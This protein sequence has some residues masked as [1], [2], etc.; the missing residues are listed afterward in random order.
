MMAEKTKESQLRTQLPAIRTHDDPMSNVSPARSRTD[1]PA[2]EQHQKEKSH[3]QKRLHS[4]SLRHR[5]FTSNKDHHKRHSAK[6]TVHSAIELKPPISFDQLLRRDKKS[7]DSSRRGSGSHHLSQQG[8]TQQLGD[9]KEWTGQHNALAARRQVKPQEVQKARQENAEREE[10]LRTSLKAVEEV[11]MKSTRQ[12]DDVYYNILEK[13]S[14]L[15]S[16]VA[17][18]QQLAEESRR[19]HTQFHEEAAKLEQETKKNLE[20]FGNFDGQERAINDLVQQLK[21]SR[22]D[23][24]KLNERLE[25]A[26]N[27]IEAYE[28]RENERQKKR[29]QRYGCMWAALIGFVVLIVAVMVA[30]NRSQV[31]S[32][33]H[34]VARVL[35]ELGG[36]IAATLTVAF[37]PAASPSEDA[38]LKKLFDD[39]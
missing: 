6:D 31:G 29:R 37:K 32:K 27:R 3:L 34:N 2:P 20:G 12:L 30:R 39:L 28:Q 10:E 35:D 33:V 19:M 21:K 23:T 16:T 26:R 17:S 24:H 7:P 13:A 9:L 15:R 25:V 5:A 22:D 36:E 38:F 11:A 4:N 18:L 14:I 1:P 8:Q